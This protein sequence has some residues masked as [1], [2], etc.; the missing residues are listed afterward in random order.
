MKK[1]RMEVKANLIA[2][3]DACEAATFAAD[4]WHDNIL[5]KADNSKDE[6]NVDFANIDLQN[7]V[8]KLKHHWQI[9]SEKFVADG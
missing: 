4:D 3:A 5:N 6:T 9:V 7:L 8:F 2:R 1:T